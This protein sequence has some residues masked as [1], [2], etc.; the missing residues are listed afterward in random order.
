MIS[1]E[2]EEGIF[3]V[4]HS[5]IPCKASPSF[6]PS[7]IKSQGVS[8]SSRRVS[9]EMNLTSIHEDAGSVPGFVPWVK[10]PVLL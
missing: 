8:W 2:R 7:S 1:H 5:F 10:D 6:V 4:L 9:A 3:I